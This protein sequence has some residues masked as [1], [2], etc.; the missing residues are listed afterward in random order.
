ML[1]LGMTGSQPALA[2]KIRQSAA[3][4]M[5]WC[6]DLPPNTNAI[7]SLNSKSE[8]W[9]ERNVHLVWITN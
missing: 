4:G 5:E 1:K 2:T 8:M 9:F 3:E 7:Q 6:I